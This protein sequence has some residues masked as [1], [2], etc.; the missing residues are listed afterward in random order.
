MKASIELQR[1]CGR[2]FAIEQV[3]II[4]EV[5]K[6]CGGISRNE[7]ANT[8]C[9]LLDWR[10]PG[11][12]LKTRECRDLLE[13]LEGKGILELPGKRKDGYTGPRRSIAEVQPEKPYSALTGSV[14]DFSPLDVELVQTREQREL[15]KEL[16]AGYH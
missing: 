10:R 5:V 12:G 9:E 4:Q 7:L 13:Q 1:F 16:L 6:T 2:E 11:G 14:E 3:S 8:V 15:F